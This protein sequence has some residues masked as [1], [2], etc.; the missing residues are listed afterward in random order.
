M[1]IKKGIIYNLEKAQLP[2]I[3]QYQNSILISFSSRDDEGK[4]FGSFA[5]VELSSD[6]KITIN[7]TL[8]TKLL[9]G[10]RGSMDASG[11]MPMQVIGKY[12]YYIG[13]TE[14]KDV[15]YFNY[16]CIASV[17]DNF[18]FTKLGPILSP[19]IIDQGFT[20]TFCVSAGL[21]NKYNGYYLSEVGW[22]KDEF[23]KL[24]PSYDIKIATSED[25]LAWNKTG[26]I[27]IQLEGDEAGISSASV[28][29]FGGIYHMWFSVR[30][31]K[32]FR[33]GVGSYEIKHAISR[34]GFEWTR[35]GKFGL[36]KENKLGENM[37]AYP[38]I[39]IGN[40]YLHM[41]YNANDFGKGGISHAIINLDKINNI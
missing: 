36:I 34:D 38:C 1:W 13:W 30:E 12:L 7:N 33:G 41:F 28:I 3:S 23:G 14:R 16:T 29:K 15:P 24:N 17:S 32:N 40:E 21:K 8:P 2:V 35:T 25:L 19:C 6:D 4:S 18:S 26:K 22:S 9:K 11:V 5:N 39:L 10:D 37:A 27:A 20:G 31:D